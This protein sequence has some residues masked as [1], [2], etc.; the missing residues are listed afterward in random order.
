MAERR[1]QKTLPFNGDKQKGEVKMNYKGLRISLGFLA[2]GTAFAISAFSGAQTE[3]NVHALKKLISQASKAN[4]AR[5]KDN[6]KKAKLLGIPLREKL[7]N[8]IL[9]EIYKFVNGRP[10][11]LETFNLGAAN[12][13]G[14]SKLWPGGSLGLSLDGSGITL[15]QWDGGVARSTHQ[16]F[17]GRLINGDGS[18]SSEHATHVAGTM[19]AAGIKSN[20]KGMSF[21]AQ[22][23][24]YDWNNDTAEM[25]TEALAGL[26]VSNH[27]YGIALPD[28]F[29]MYEE[30]AVE[31]DTLAY[32][33]PFYLIVQ[34]AGNFGPGSDTIANPAPAKNILTVGNIRKNSYSGPASVVLN[35]SSSIGPTDDGRIKPDLVAPGTDL[36]SCI[37]ASDT[38]YEA[39]T[40]TSMASPVVAGSMGLLVQY[41]QMLFPGQ[42]LRSATLKAL[43]IHTA[44]EAG[45]ADGPDYRFGWGQLNV[46]NAAVTLQQFVNN[47]ATIQEG[48]LNQGQTFEYTATSDGISPIRV[49]LVWTDPPGTAASTS[50][51][52]TSKLINDLDLRVQ[53]GGQT[54]LPWVLDPTRPSQPASRGDNARDNV[55]QVVVPATPG[56][57]RIVLSHKGTTL[58]PSGRQAFSLIVTGLSSPRL[59]ELTINPDRIAS[60]KTGTGTVSLNGSAPAGGM[61][62][63]LQ[64]SDRSVARVPATV[65][66]PAGSQSASFPIRAASVIEA[67]MA[68]ITATQADLSFSKQVTVAPPGLIRLELNPTTVDGGSSVQGLVELGVPAPAGGALVR[69]ATDKKKVADVAWAVRIPEGETIGNFTITTYPVTQ[70][71]E[72]RVRAAYPGPTRYAS[73]IVNPPFM[74]SSVSLSRS[75]VKGGQ[76]VIGTVTMARAA[77]ADTIVT[78]SSSMPSVAAVP[79][80]V[81]IPAGSN[82]ATFTVT[83]FAVASTQTPEITATYNSI[84]KTAKL[85]VTK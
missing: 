34:A 24:G 4:L 8:G 71:T 56:Q 66:V 47:P 5:K 64:S 33:A 17:T 21:A 77:T 36:Y 10:I 52:P 1:F 42:K 59:S 48:V 37:D 3:T 32:N 45:P 38:T 31:R 41:Y 80:T 11:Y 60:G 84:T 16:E 63:Q 85:K 43:A 20:A 28:R 74:L 65:R 35:E 19:I 50:N 49:T 76:N 6:E 72:V 46:A 12:T 30:Y 22:L 15:G 14:A 25:S 7:P 13:V 55:E 9:R 53:A 54:Y 23:R 39:G 83:T 40:G 81:T 26:Q 73:L 44:D 29:G 69:V 27:S 61:I 18:N 57:V 2:L 78:L 82:K 58:Q 51:D 62:I 70:T 75:S 68:T 79:T 67:K